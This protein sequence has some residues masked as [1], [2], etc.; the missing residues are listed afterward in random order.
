M[1]QY[2]RQHAWFL[3]PFVMSSFSKK[4]ILSSKKQ[5]R[6]NFFRNRRFSCN[7]Y[8]KFPRKKYNALFLCVWK[9]C[10]LCKFVT[11]AFVNT[12]LD[13]TLRRIGYLHL[14]LNNNFL[15]SSVRRLP[16]WNLVITCFSTFNMRNV[17]TVRCLGNNYMK[18]NGVNLAELCQNLSHNVSAF[19]T[20]FDVLEYST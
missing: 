2:L 18:N 14:G 13:R 5:F 15:L 8:T 20:Y 16:E 12:N 3:Q 17:L 11:T 19:L 10:R 7:W 1:Y 4:I 6:F 9:S